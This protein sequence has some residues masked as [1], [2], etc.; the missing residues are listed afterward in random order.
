[1]SRVFDVSCGIRASTSPTPT[2]WPSRT[3]MIE[4]IWKVMFT[5]TSEPAIFTSLPALV[6]ELHLRAQ[7]LSPATRTALRIDDDRGSKDRSLRRSD[8]RP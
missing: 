1:M 7:T 3:V 5:D 8:E 4:P 2:S 6:D